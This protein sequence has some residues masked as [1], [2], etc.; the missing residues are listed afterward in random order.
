MSNGDSV[1][2]VDSSLYQESPFFSNT[3]PI[4]VQGGWDCSLGSMVGYTQIDGQ[5][6]ING[7]AAVTISNI[8]IGQ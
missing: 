1:I 8:I 4:T 6:T 2:N 7:K 5:V 3:V